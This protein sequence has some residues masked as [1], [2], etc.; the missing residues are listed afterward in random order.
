MPNYLAES[1]VEEAA[2]DWFASLGFSVVHG[3][4]IAPGELTAERSNY[5]EVILH[6]RLLDALRRFNPQ[7]PDD[8]LDNVVRRVARRDSPSLIG[9]NHRLHLMLVDGAEVLYTREDGRVVGDRAKLIDFDDP[10]NNDWCVVNQFTV[11]EGQHARRPDVV[12]FVNGMPLAVFELKDASNA[13][14]TV[15]DAFNQLQTYKKQVPA[16]MVPN[17]ALV[18]SDGVQARV[19]S[20]TADTERFMPWR[21]IEGRELASPLI[22][23]LQVLIDGVF[24]KRRFLDF[25][26][27]FVV[28]ENDGK[29][30]S[31][32]LAA[33]HQFHAVNRAIDETV[34]AA[35]EEGNRR[36]GIVWHT[37]GSGKSL[38]MAFYSG[39]LVLHP[40]MRNPTLVILTDRNDLDEQLYGVFSRCREL[41]R[42]EPQQASDRAHLRE[43]LTRASGGVL[44][45]TIQKFLPDAKG[46]PYP[47]LSER[48]NIVVIADEAHRSQ[49]DFIDGFARH[50]RDALP[51]ASFIGFTGTPIELE[52]RSTRAV[53]GEYI[54]VY[55]VQQAVEDGATVPIFYENRLAKLA[56]DEEERPKL[57]ENFEEVT[58]G[59][60]VAR[61]EKLKSKWAALE[62]IVGTDKRLAGS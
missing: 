10:S 28:F 2:L 47:L 6:R 13:Q 31:K 26:R 45:T 41:L 32:K 58:E 19:G 11:V 18:V 61:V 33:Y 35:S 30:L 60:E 4:D 37:Q 62:A 15:W 49:Y 3:P 48:R 43:L 12:V 40:A 27:H 55:D 51:N 14:A 46:D 9:D 8:A 7:I 20:L 23:Q 53:F 24:D 17:V 42:Q 34:R 5:R 44:F 1:H 21:T 38:T 59:E 25:V 39:R 50:M 36:V 16:L 22:P 57:D 54:S 29:Q 52:D 56:L